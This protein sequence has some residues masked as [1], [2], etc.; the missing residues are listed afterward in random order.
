MSKINLRLFS[1]EATNPTL[2]KNF[3]APNLRSIILVGVDIPKRLSLLSSTFSLVTLKLVGVQASDHLFPRKLVSRLRS[4]PQLENLV[5]DFCD[6]MPR[7]GAGS[8]AFGAPGTPVTLPCLKD[9]KFIGF[10]AGLECLVAQIRTPL[11]EWLA[12]T[13]FYQDS[14]ELPHLIHF[15]KITEGLKAL[16]TGE[17]SFRYEGVFVSMD[18]HRTQWDIGQLIL[19]VMCYR[20]GQQIFSAV[21][22]CRALI[23]VL[24]G[25]ERLRLG[26]DFGKTMEGAREI[27]SIM[28]HELLRPFTAAKELRI[29][30]ELSEELSSALQEDDVGSDPGFLPDLQD[31]VSDFF[32]K[33]ADAPFDSFIH[34]RRVAGRLVHP[35]LLRLNPPPSRTRYRFDPSPRRVWPRKRR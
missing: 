24:S 27:D 12:V 5:I 1:D 20:L 16:P 6:D 25:V 33:D 4:L 31:L 10:S 21:Q 15:I 2:P 23:P 9:L 3:L 32:W 22:I 8:E 30:P 18:Q 26:L 34:A 7:P 29:S 28:W 11:L 17:I 14:F 35:T 13:L 19:D